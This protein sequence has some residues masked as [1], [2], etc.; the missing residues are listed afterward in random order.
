MAEDSRLPSDQTVRSGR[1]VIVH[2]EQIL[3]AQRTRIWK[4]RETLKH[5][6]PKVTWWSHYDLLYL[7]LVQSWSHS[8]LTLVWDSDVWWKTWNQQSWCPDMFPPRCH[9]YIHPVRVN[10]VSILLTSS[11]CEIKKTKKAIFR[12]KMFVRPSWAIYNVKLSS[13]VVNNSIYYS[14]PKTGF[15]IFFMPMNVDV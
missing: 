3:H 1:K 15:G 2:T 9:W 6:R 13:F 14:V 7:L 12:K 5:K 8:L 11:I 10:T 4:Q